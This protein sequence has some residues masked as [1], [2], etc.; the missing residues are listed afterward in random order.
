M[1]GSSKR[2]GSVVAFL[3]VC[4]LFSLGFPAFA[5]GSKDVVQGSVEGLENW[6]TEFDVTGRKPGV[7]NILVE[8]SDAAGNTATAGP[9]NVRIDPE[10]DLPKVSISYPP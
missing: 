3:I 7:Y 6:Q 2:S 9:F 5:G 8:G 1:P 10:T 4:S